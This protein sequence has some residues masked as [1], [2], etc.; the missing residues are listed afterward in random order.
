GDRYQRGAGNMAKA[1]AE[2]AGCLEATGE[3]VKAFCCAPVHGA[4]TAA[5]L[6]EAKVFRNVIV[7]GG[8]SLAKLGMK[9]ESHLKHDMPVLEDVLGSMA[10]L[11]APD[12]GL[13]PR[14]RLDI[15]G[16]HRVKAGAS[17][18]AIAEALVL[19][20]LGS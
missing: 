16:R 13:N 19:E 17:A 5:A 4:V 1:V 6:V 3:D 9:F 10:V 12:D 11:I 18:Q 20:P 8:G 7:F 2:M 15:V 14:I